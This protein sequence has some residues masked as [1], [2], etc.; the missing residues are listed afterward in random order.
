MGFD[1]Y[2]Y[3]LEENYVHN[4]IINKIV[5]IKEC[6]NPCIPNISSCTNVLKL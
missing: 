3:S 6:N 2:T 1:D 5:K 4:N